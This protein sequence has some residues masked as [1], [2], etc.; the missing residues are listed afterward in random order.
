M[1]GTVQLGLPY[2]RRAAEGPLDA[3]HCI[4]VLDRAWSLG[5]RSFDTAEAYGKAAAML[6]GWIASRGIAEK[7][8]VVTKLAVGA[9]PDYSTVEAATSRFST[10]GECV[11]M[12]HDAV[13]GSTFA[14]FAEAVTGLG[15]LP[16]ASVYTAEDVRSMAAA[17]ACRLQA[18]M[19]VF[20][21]RQSAAARKSGVPID[22]RSVFLQGVL[23]EPP[24]SADARAPGTGVLAGI[25][26][27]AAAAVGVSPA[28]ALL[29]CAIHDLGPGDRVVVGVDRAEEL[30][31]IVGGIA[32][33]RGT[34]IGF[35]RALKSELGSWRPDEPVLDPRTWR[36][37]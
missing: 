29:A 24:A 9:A 2:G 23:L 15:A 27:R 22:C 25:V 13:N 10:V 16:G 6:E 20:D 4:R 26:Q 7:C 32:L 19:N 11:V 12:T 18:P 35:R 34:L 37:A 3:V 33:D 8:R 36:A 1:L 28:V 5:I 21:G 17:G 30:D 31:A 14:E